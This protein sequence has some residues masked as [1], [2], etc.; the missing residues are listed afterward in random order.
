MQ[1]PW[2]QAPLKLQFC[3]HMRVAQL[4]PPKPSGQRAPRVTARARNL[5]ESPSG[6]RISSYSSRESGVTLR[7]AMLPGATEGVAGAGPVMAISSAEGM[8]TSGWCCSPVA[9]V[10]PVVPVP[11]VAGS[12]SSGES[13]M[14]PPPTPPKLPVVRPLGRSHWESQRMPEK[15]G[16]QTQPYSG[17][18]TPWKEHSLGQTT[19]AHV[20]PLKPW[21]HSHL[22]LVHSPWLLQSSGQRVSSQKVP[23]NSLSH[24]HAPSSALQRP[25]PWQSCTSHAM[26]D[27]CSWQSHT[28]SRQR[29]CSQPCV[30]SLREQSASA[31][32]SRQEQVPL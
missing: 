11:P 9:P 26:P 17:V 3:G 16:S 28:P 23:A 18:H 21:W 14:S 27:Q 22:W 15:P 12:R 31:Q 19:T 4:G 29:P 2:W 25:W 5:G 10:A 8:C 6:P 1:L 32:P 24:L 13:T 30:H 7:E 20:S